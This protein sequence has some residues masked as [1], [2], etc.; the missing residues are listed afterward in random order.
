VLLAGGAESVQLATLRAL[1]PA[2][3]SIRGV[4][5]TGGDGAIN[6]GM[7]DAHAVFCP[8]STAPEAAKALAADCDVI[9]SW[10]IHGMASLKV[11]APNRPKWTAIAHSSSPNSREVERIWLDESIDKWVAVSPLALDSI[12]ECK[13]TETAV[14]LNAVDEARLE[15]TG[16]PE[17]TTRAKRTAW[18]V[19][20][21][22]KVAGFLGRLSPEKNPMAMIRL[23]EALPDNWH[24]VLVGD[25]AER[26]SL[27]EAIRFTGLEGRVHLVGSDARAGDVLRAFDVLVVPSIFESFG[28][29]LAEGLW[30]GV[31]VVSTEVGI[32]KMVPGLARSVSFEATGQALADAVLA[33]HAT[34][35]MPGAQAWARERLSFERF[36]AEWNTLLREVG[37]CGRAE[38]EA[39]TRQERQ[40]WAASAKSL[41][42][43]GV[44]LVRGNRASDEVVAERL[45]ICLGCPYQRNEAVA[46]TVCACGGLGIATYVGLDMNL[47]RSL[48]GS[49]CALKVAKW[50]AV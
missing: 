23:A 13:R 14:I 10:A 31:P 18:G 9:V 47:K 39:N 16:D 44:D 42:T 38:R 30:L 28:L 15:P 7:R 27:D 11:D 48:K 4:A 26:A 25:G 12:P 21:G 41:V 37:E 1:D 20:V 24:C 19:P 2:V 45:A 5:V 32:A 33:A 6:L 50:G 3:F 34:G 49:R 36:A 29:T 46:C 17:I 35:A 8:V 22:A 40:G 43:A